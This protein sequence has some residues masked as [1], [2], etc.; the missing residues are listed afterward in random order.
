[1]SDDSKLQGVYVE[2]VAVMACMGLYGIT[3]MQ[4]YVPIPPSLASCVARSTAFHRATCL[5]WADFRFPA[6][7]CSF[8][9]FVKYVPIPPPPLPA[10]HLHLCPLCRPVPRRYSGPWSC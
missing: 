8:L 9:Y 7:P 10:S 5:A 1:M 6:C 3:C 4:T 2:Y